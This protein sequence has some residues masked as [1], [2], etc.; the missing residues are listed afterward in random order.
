MTRLLGGG[1]VIRRLLLVPAYAF[2]LFACSSEPTNAPTDNMDITIASF[3][4]IWQQDSDP[5]Y[6]RVELDGSFEVASSRDSF[7]SNALDEGKL[8]FSNIALSFISNDDSPNC[9]G[10][11]GTYRVTFNGE[12]QFESRVV[13]DECAP[14]RGDSRTPPAKWTRI[15][16]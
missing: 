2:L 4:G 12:D 10:Q 15:S 16:D 13:E 9:G 6:M 7:E 11:T 3:A 8:L 1:T 5:I 14:F